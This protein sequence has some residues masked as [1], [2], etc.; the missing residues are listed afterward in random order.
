MIHIRQA[1]EG[2]REESDPQN[3]I[4]LAKLQVFPFFTRQDL[5]RLAQ[6]KNESQN[7]QLYMEQF[8]AKCGQ[9]TISER[10]NEPGQL[11]DKAQYALAAEETQKRQA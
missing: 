8:L 11:L 9:V 2:L 7:H 6:H 1:F 4:S 10:G 3:E 5:A